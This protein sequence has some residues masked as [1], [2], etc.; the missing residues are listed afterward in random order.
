M[1]VPRQANALCVNVATG[2][3]GIT[4]NRFLPRKWRLGFADAGIPDVTGSTGNPHRPTQAAMRQ[5]Q[6]RLKDNRCAYRGTLIPASRCLLV[7]E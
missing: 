6:G 3:T 4:G 1:Q 7:V 5:I 2:N